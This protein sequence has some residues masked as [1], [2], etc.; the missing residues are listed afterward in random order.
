MIRTA[1]RKTLLLAVATLGMGALAVNCSRSGT[2]N[3]DSSS[4]LGS[5]GLAI[6]L[7]SGATVSSVHYSVKNS[8]GA[9]V[10]WVTSRPAIR[11]PRSP[12]SSAAFPPGPA[13]PSS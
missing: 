13:T 9:E 1:A 8:G 3:S 2:G 6:S 12:S 7:P 11:A 5:V 10:R 4:N